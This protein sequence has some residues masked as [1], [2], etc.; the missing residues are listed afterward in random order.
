VFYTSGS[1]CAEG[2]FKFSQTRAQLLRHVL[3]AGRWIIRWLVSPRS[4]TALTVRPM[5]SIFYRRFIRRYSKVWLPSVIT[6]GGHL[7]TPNPN[8]PPATA[9]GCLALT[10][11][12]ARLRRLP[13]VC[14]CATPAAAPLPPPSAAYAAHPLEIRAHATTNSS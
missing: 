9:R 8:S 10:P 7:L 6:G 14:V 2:I 5:L 1:S 3:F 13:C 4:R 12:S 11:P